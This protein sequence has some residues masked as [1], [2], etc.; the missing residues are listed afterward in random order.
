MPISL[1][2][3]SQDPKMESTRPWIVQKYGGTSIGKLLDTIAVSILPESL[4]TYN[5]AV[6]CSARS[7]TSKS[8]GTTALLLKAIHYATS[9]ESS[10]ADILSAIE[11]I[12]EEHLIAARAISVKKNCVDVNKTALEDLQSSIKDD[13]EQL[14]KFLMATWTVGEISERAQDRV[15]A[16]GEKLAVRIVVAAF[17][18]QVCGFD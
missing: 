1:S 12:Q 10:P 9:S 17:E 5:V 13:C 3:V 16:V 11:I 6:V 18:S 2:R 4:R 14:R 7:G 8:K 15:L